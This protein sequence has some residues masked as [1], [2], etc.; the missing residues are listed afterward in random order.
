MLENIYNKFFYK[1][2]IWGI[3]TCKIN[4][5]KNTSN[6]EK[7]FKQVL[8]H[9]DVTD[10]KAVFLADPFV[11][12]HNNI[13]YMFFEILESKSRKGVI[14]FA[15][16]N[17]GEQWKYEKVVLKE[18]FHLSYPYV[19]EDNGEIYMIPETGQSGYIKVYKSTNFPYK[20]ECI[21]NIIVG[22][23]WDSSIFKYDN[24]WWIL[25]RTSKPKKNSL[26]LFYSENLLHGWKEH[27][28]SPL[29]I[30]DSSKTRPG[31]RVFVDKDRIIR[32]SQDHSKYYGEKVRAFEIRE[33]NDDKYAEFELGII[34]N[35]SDSHRTWNKDGMHT[36]EINKIKEDEYL[37]V[38]DG[39][40]Y[41]DINKIVAKIKNIFM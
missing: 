3:G 10:V 23:Y 35:K 21:S 16:S 18:K 24:K 14:G 6:L 2:A 41:K 30:G 9:K 1:E 26:A 28:M 13:W 5:L 25:S 36:F 20:W 7:N 27:R 37:L 4:N 40:Y 29:I 39:F 22:E 17:D 19:F 38:A 33:L 15:T 31:G 34:I 12:N 8:S 32:F 11:I